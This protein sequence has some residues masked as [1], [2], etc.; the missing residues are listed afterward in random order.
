MR[1]TALVRLR[2][3]AAAIQMSSEPSHVQTPNLRALF[4]RLTPFRRSSTH[5]T[6]DSGEMHFLARQNQEYFS[7]VP[8]A[9]Q[10]S[11]ANFDA[12]PL[13]ILLCISSTFA[14][15]QKALVRPTGVFLN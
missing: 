8:D 14:R 4:R 1:V 6:G 3:A 12:V 5:R 13:L 2:R 11:T 9:G 15:K 7:V 10:R